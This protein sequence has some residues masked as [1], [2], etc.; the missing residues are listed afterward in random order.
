V[1]S[2]ETRGF[3][4]DGGGLYLQVGRSGLKSRVFRYAL[5]GRKRDMGLGGIAPFTLAEVRAGAQGRQLV[6][7][8]IDPIDARSK[9]RGHCGHRVDLPAMRRAVCRG[10]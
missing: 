2:L 5:N 4:C 7:D 8:G 3:Y 1:Q 6:A 9:T 10:A